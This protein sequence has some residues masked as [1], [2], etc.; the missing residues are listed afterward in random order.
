VAT[1]TPLPTY[2]LL[3]VDPINGDLHGITHGATVADNEFTTIHL[4]S[5]AAPTKVGEVQLKIT[6]TQAIGVSVPHGV[7]GTWGLRTFTR[8]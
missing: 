2:L 7:V 5:S 1:A 6:P 3:L 4:Q 8:T